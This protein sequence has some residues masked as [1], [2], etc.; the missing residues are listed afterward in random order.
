VAR[1]LTLVLLSLAVIGIVVF[2]VLVGETT[3]D[4]G[5]PGARRPLLDTLFETVSAFGTVG[6]STGITA[7]LTTWSKAWII[8]MMVMGRVGILT[9]SYIIIGSGATKGVE[10]AEESVMVG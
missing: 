2:M 10:H 6:L 4:I 8:V 7:K 1:G 5:G 9:F 3:T